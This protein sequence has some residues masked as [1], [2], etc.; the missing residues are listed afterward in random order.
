MFKKFLE[1][2]EA[3]DMFVT[4]AAGTGKTTDMRKDVQH[5]IDNEIPY[6]VCAYTHKA[7]GILRSK[8]PAGARVQTLHS[9]LGKR[10][11][12]NSS[13]VKMSEVSSSM[14]TSK[15]DEE[16]RVMFL[17]EYSMVGDKDT[18]D[19]RACQDPMY[20]G[21]PILKLVAYGDHHQLPP[22]GDKQTLKAEGS[23]Y[24]KKLTKQYRNDNP[25][26]IPL[27]KLISY[28]DKEAQPEPL[29]SIPGFF[30]R[31]IDIDKVRFRE[32]DKVYLAFTNKR[33]EDLNYKIQ[34]YEFPANDDDVFSP[35]TQ[36]HYVFKHSVEDVNCI[37]LHYTDPL[38]LGS[39]FKTLEGLIDSE[40]CS[41]G[42]FQDNDGAEFVF[43]YVFGHYRFKRL[44]EELQRAAVASN[45]AIE[46]EFKG[47]KAVGWAKVNY[48]H[49]L[50]RER[51][52]AWR[53][54]LSFD[55]CVVCMDFVHAMTVHKSQGS[56][57]HTVILDTDDLAIAAERNFD[58][59]LTLTYVGMSRASHKVYTP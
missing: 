42:L 14:Q 11:T 57:F 32:P 44:R 37:D 53:E 18:M 55:D 22:V 15:P 40:N 54:F 12:V 47:Y 26:Q 13:A 2:S 5:C 29:E 38:S 4:G 52:K 59:Y 33:V 6:V 10:P 31:G 25:L 21:Q 34:G 1:D 20:T 8:L 41:F 9:F 16:P 7:C 39:K 45:K 35:T 17:D 27:K 3:W 50:A 19:I 58:L 28:I 46:D 23:K 43:A 51:S 48:T 30:E 49:K 36:H 56:T 24:H